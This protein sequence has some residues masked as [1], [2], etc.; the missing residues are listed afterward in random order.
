MIDEPFSGIALLG[1]VLRA[2]PDPANVVSTLPFEKTDLRPIIDGE[3]V[4]AEAELTNDAHGADEALLRLPFRVVALPSH[5]L[6]SELRL[7]GD[8]INQFVQER[9][10]AEV[11]SDHLRKIDEHVRQ[12][13]TPMGHRKRR[14]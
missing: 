8:F 14:N 12:G 1:L 7:G 4:A 13:L 5:S 6:A 10:R 3:V 11:L 9:V 2:L